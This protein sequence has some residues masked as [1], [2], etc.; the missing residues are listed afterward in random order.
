[1]RLLKKHFSLFVRLIVP[2][3]FI[4]VYFCLP[5][6]KI[7]VNQAF[8][9]L[10]NSDAVFTSNH[11]AAFQENSV[12]AA[13]LMKLFQS[14]FF[15]LPEVETDSAIFLAL[16]KIARF[17]IFAGNWCAGVLCFSIFR[18]IS[19]PVH[20]NPVLKRVLLCAVLSVPPVPVSL[21]AV[22][23]GLSGS[24]GMIEF[25]LCLIPALVLRLFI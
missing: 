17:V 13:F 6:V 9:V 2:A 7:A 21:A 23:A 16:G 4:G 25:I 1:M 5:G 10:N 3:A 19:H 8:F 22:L 11:I 20:V 14:L 18:N 24:F 12:V 15:I